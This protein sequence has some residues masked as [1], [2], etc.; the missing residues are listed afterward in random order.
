MSPRVW[1]LQLDKHEQWVRFKFL[2]L[3]IINY[4]SKAKVSCECMISLLWTG[5]FYH[6][7]LSIKS[8]LCV[9][10]ETA[11]VTLFV[12]MLTGIW[13][14]CDMTANHVKSEEKSAHQNIFNHL[15]KDSVWLFVIFWN[16]FSQQSVE[17]TWHHISRRDISNP[18]SQITWPLRHY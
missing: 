5:W 11:A 7:S 8:L 17:A 9:L 2:Y 1:G 15:F 6:V 16:Q 3:K 10:H 13:H 14:T 4:M 18:L 12:Q